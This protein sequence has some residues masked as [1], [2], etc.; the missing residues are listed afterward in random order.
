M[1]S[2]HD[3]HGSEFVLS[4]ST[5]SK[6]RS[7]PR[8]VP[9]FQVYSDPGP[10]SLNLVAQ[11]ATSLALARH[12]SLHL[13]CVPWSV[14]SLNMLVKMILSEN[15]LGSHPLNCVSV[16]VSATMC[17]QDIYAIQFKSSRWQC[18]VSL[19]QD[20]FCL[21]FQNFEVLV[22]SSEP[23]PVQKTESEKTCTFPVSM[24][25]FGSS[26]HRWFFHSPSVR[27]S[28]EH[29]SSS[30]KTTDSPSCSFSRR[31]PVRI[32]SISCVFEKE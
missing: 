28:P 5:V 7:W 22:E 21:L 8:L 20:C 1:P 18:L 25:P 11:E 16:A 24:L 3:H 29:L 26:S 32:F 15:L 14:M 19:F 31:L 27:H 6:L 23:G 10:T 9:Y 12:L 17:L 13:L 2:S 4:H 30:R